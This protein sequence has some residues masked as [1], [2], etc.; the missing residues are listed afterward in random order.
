MLWI[1]RHWVSLLELTGVGLLAVVVI[2]GAQAYGRHRSLSA[3]MAMHSA[4]R[5]APGSKEKLDA[6]EEIAKDYSRYFA[7]KSAMMQLGEELSSEKKIDEAREQLNRLADGSRNQPILRIAALHRL[8]ELELSAGDAAAAAAT[9]QKAAADPSN[10]ISLYSQ[11]MAAAC[12][13]KA[14]DYKG[15]AELYRMIIEDAGEDDERVRG[16][17]EER[18]I[19]LAANGR[20]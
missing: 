2:A 20:I 4:D 18:M 8:A 5:M 1:K 15:A 6:L 17:S 16:M 14:S 12:L 13:E 10:L 3:A 9:Y 19:W 11:L 7:G